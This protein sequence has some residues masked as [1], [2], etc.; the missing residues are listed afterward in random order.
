MAD[1]PNS[2]NDDNGAVAAL[3]GLAF[4][5][6]MLWKMAEGL[7]ATASENETKRL[8]EAAEDFQRRGLFREALEK[9]NQLLS[10]KPKFAP[11]YNARAWIYA[12]H[13]YELHQALIDINTA[14]QLSSE[15]REIAAFYDTRGE[16]WMR[17][18]QPDAAI[19]DFFQSLQIFQSSEQLNPDYSTSYRIATCLITKGDLVNASGWLDR[20]LSLNPSNP[21]IY[22]AAG[23]VYMARGYYANAVDRFT[24]AIHQMS[25]SAI[26]GDQRSYFLSIVWC[27][28]SAALYHLEE[29]EKCRQANI[30]SMQAYSFNPFPIINLASLAARDSDKLQMRQWLERG[31]PLIDPNFHPALLTFL[32]GHPNFDE[33]RDVVLELLRNEGKIP[34]TTYQQHRDGWLKRR[35]QSSQSSP[36]INIRDSIL[37][38]LNVGDNGKIQG[39]T[40][41]KSDNK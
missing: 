20:A 4:A 7:S 17:S 18:N 9:L 25:Q 32:L 22:S 28:T 39:T 14:L 15:P 2:S 21:W 16:I 30:A 33:Y 41:T 11:A 29:Y 35:S 34:L 40:I 12:I 19:S 36:T 38:G 37:G 26:T 10:K 3:A 27:N 1:T 31:I 8:Y 24:K 13:N 5:G 6:A 23:D